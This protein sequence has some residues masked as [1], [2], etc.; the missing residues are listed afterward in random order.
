M[1][2]VAH[3]ISLVKGGRQLCQGLTLHA[4]PGEWW[5]ILGPNGCGKTTLL[6]AFA[7]LQPLTAGHI[8]Y[9]EQPLHSLCAKYI[10]Q[11]IGM[12]FQ[13]CHTLF[14]QTVQ[15]FCQ[16][17][18]YPHRTLYQAHNDEDDAIVQEALHLTELWHVSQKKI[19]QLSGGEKKRLAIA[20]LL[21]QTPQIY[22]LDEPTNHLD[23]KHQFAI[24]HHFERLIREQTVTVMMAIHDINLA[25]RF[26]DHVLLLFDDGTH[27]HG[28]THKILTRENLTRL[29]AHPIT[30]IVN[31]AQVFWLPDKRY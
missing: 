10:A 14:A 18:R 20:A 28:A 23:I 15:E 13:E 22:L 9:H 6:Q 1:S 31:Q 11:H 21:A 27:A 30:P 19:T 4:R 17:S 24:L 8:S 29:Y 25:Q 2:V 26:C 12:L 3:D 7:G 16:T 5:G